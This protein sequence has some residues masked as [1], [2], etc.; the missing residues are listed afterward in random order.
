[1]SNFDALVSKLREIFQIDRPDLDFGVYRILNARAGEIEDYLSKR[2]KVRV[3]EALA[4]GAAANT[5]TLK[6]DIAKAEK[7][8]EDAGI[9][10]DQSPRVQQ[11][12]AQLAAASAGSSEHENQVFSHLLT[13]FSRYYD[14]GDFISQRRYKGDTYAIP[15][16]GEEVVLH[17]ANRDQYYT[18]SGESFSN[19]SFK[20]EDGRTVQFR[21]VAAD[22][23]KDNRKDNDKERRF[24]LASARTITRVDEDGESFEETIQPVAEENGALVIRFDYAPQPKGTKQEALVEQ[25]VT[26]I[27]D[28]EVVKARWLALTARAPTE[29]KP[30]RTLLER[31]LTTYTQ[32]NTA[33]YFI[34]KDL[35]AFL[36]R[37]LDFFIKNEV[38]NLDDVQEAGTF[39]AIEKNLRMI[40]C[41]RAMA[42]DLI[43]FLASIEGFQKK[44]WLKKKFV[45]AAHYCVTLDR[46]PEALYPAIAAIPAQWV[47]WH[48]LGMRA[49][50]AAGTVEDLKSSPFLMV[51][52]ALFDM[53]LRAE[54]LKSLPDIDASLDGLLVHGDNFQALTLLSKRFEAKARTLY[55]DPPYNTDASAIIYKNGYKD[56]SWLSL[57]DQSLRSSI[58]LAKSEAVICGS[59]DDTE[60]SGMREVFSQSYNK[61]IGIGIV[62]ANPQS[63]KTSGKFS[64][65]HEYAIFY[66][67]TDAA[68]PSSL[69]FSQKKAER[70]PLVDDTGHYSWMNFVRAGNADLRTDRPKSFYPIWVHADGEIYVPKLN[71]RDEIKAYDV[72]EER[73]EGVEE[74]YPIKYGDGQV[75]EKRWQRGHERVRKEYAEY[76]ARRDSAGIMNIDFKTRMDD[77]AAPTTWWDKS[78][79]A[80]SNFGAAELADIVPRNDFDYPKT[81][82]FVMDALR[83]SGATEEDALCIDFFAGSGTTGHAVIE[84][85][86]LDNGGRKYILVEQGSYFGSIIKPRM[87]KAAFS[88][89]WKSGKPIT[90]ETGI[91]HA[92]KVLK[93]EG[94][95]DTLNNLDLKR[96]QVQTTLLDGFSADK[97]DDYLMRYMLDVESK[98]SLLS[99]SDFRTPFDYKLKVSVDSAGAWEERKVDLVETFNYLIGLTVRHIDIQMKQGFVTVEGSLPS[100]EKTLILWRD[101]EKIGYEELTR[102]CDKLA[103]NP[104]DS[105]FDVV[106]INGDH[107]IPSVTET[108]EEEGSLVKKLMLRQIEPAFL[109][110]MFNVDDV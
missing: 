24:V 13:F 36:R 52:T 91:S 53:A 62:R 95:E 38:M 16:S 20:L 106:Y 107:N 50:P 63:R 3:A 33:D 21:I 6:A 83:A 58:A 35:G 86:R 71:W 51:D 99:V 109:D 41:M 74:V 44:L 101:C 18:K 98:A 43:T 46:V 23:A 29:K 77:E 27:L 10:A 42:L 17:W 37:E 96:E 48:D 67:R 72:L 28:D 32:K 34:H 11:L 49:S 80:S 85:N 45:V 103:I 57:I 108:T 110:A 22:T 40:Q 56:S 31:H 2:L 59:I 15:Y 7:A 100:G 26:A 1:M 19:F 60:V 84:L 70:Y 64:P 104:A 89:E 78:E 79:Y 66:G 39:S 88:G 47:Q 65:V 8:A 105:E 93:I 9:S 54:L 102:L 14:K 69:G 12:R 92:F 97:R 94:Y 76:R 30:N 55:I 81:K 5:E 82:G 61:Q 4:A 25:A 87:Q 73:P 90:P 68:Q 75:I